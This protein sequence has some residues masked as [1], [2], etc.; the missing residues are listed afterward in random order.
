MTTKQF[1]L[2]MILLLC[3]RSPIL[4]SN[5]IWKES[6]KTDLLLLRQQMHFNITEK[7]ARL[8][9]KELLSQT[10]ESKTFQK[11]FVKIYRKLNSE[12]RQEQKFYDLDTKHGKDISKEEEWEKKTEKELKK[13]DKYSQAGFRVKVKR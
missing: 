11:E 1:H 2:Q 3:L 12:C 10:W 9:R 13:L 8:F 7:Y 4:I 5:Q 6:S